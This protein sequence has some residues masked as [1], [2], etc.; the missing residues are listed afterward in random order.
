VSHPKHGDST[1]VF[2]MTG[3]GYDTLREMLEKGF[4]TGEALADAKRTQ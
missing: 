1:T 2:R 3:S 4:L